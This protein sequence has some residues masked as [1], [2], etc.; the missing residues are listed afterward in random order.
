MTPQVVEN[1]FG[2][3]TLYRSDIQETYHSIHGA[4]AES[5]HVFIEAGFKFWLNNINAKKVSILEVG[6]GTGLN[7]ILTL[8]EANLQTLQVNY[9]ALE[10]LALPFPLIDKLGYEKEL[11]IENELFFSAMHLGDWEIGLPI[12]PN[13]TLHKTLQAIERFES[14][15]TFDLVY[16]DAF[17]PDKQ[18][19]LWQPEIFKKIFDLM[20][21]G[22]VFVTYSAKGDVRRGLQA[23]GF[24]VSKLE[25][26]PHKRHMLRAVKN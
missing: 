1:E 10:T 20:K 9:T 17:G 5:K 6:F 19:E 15:K 12:R 3:R 26:P 13:F 25:G 4:I 24:E 22:G 16:F 8:L 18:S 23:A 2:Q 14:H 21:I 7:A 11:G